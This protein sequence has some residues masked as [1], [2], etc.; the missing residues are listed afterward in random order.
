MTS[1]EKQALTYTAGA[2]LKVLGVATLSL[3]SVYIVGRTL[4]NIGLTPDQAITTIA[5]G[6]LVW[7]V[8]MLV[9]S[10]YKSK[11]SSLNRE[12]EYAAQAAKREREREEE[13]VQRE[14]YWANINNRLKG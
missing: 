11:L 2:T 9:Y 5:V 3:G 14:A 8:S 12:D 1:N 7:A 13:R 4:R 10:E 6:F